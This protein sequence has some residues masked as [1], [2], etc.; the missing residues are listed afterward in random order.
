ME[1]IVDCHGRKAAIIAS[2]FLV[3]EWYS[4]LEANTTAADAILGRIVHT[5]QRFELKGAS[6]RKK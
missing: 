2:Q 3:S 6:L 4:I 1:I 5:A